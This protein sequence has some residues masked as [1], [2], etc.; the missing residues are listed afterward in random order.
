MFSCLL[1]TTA[2]AVAA[3]AELAII[4]EIP[5]VAHK[6]AAMLA[7]KAAA[8]QSLRI[9]LNPNLAAQSPL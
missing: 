9:F 1:T 7:A 4:G 6:E 3:A 5:I 2:T 8:A